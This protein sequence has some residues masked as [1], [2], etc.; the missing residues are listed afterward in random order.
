LDNIKYILDIEFELNFME[1][2][3][4]KYMGY[5]E[6]SLYVKG[7]RYPPVERKMLDYYTSKNMVSDEPFHPIHAAEIMRIYIYYHM[8]EISNYPELIL[9]NPLLDKEN[10]ENIEIIYYGLNRIRHIVDDYICK[11][12]PN[13]TAED[14]QHLIRFMDAI[15][16]KYDYVFNE[17]VDRALE[18]DIDTKE[19]ILIFKDPIIKIRYDEAMRIK[20][21]ER[22]VKK[23]MEEGKEDGYT[24]N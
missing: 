23:L 4:R 6:G 10:K 8:C 11:F 12:I 21:N 3:I 5:V 7:F 24:A 17:N 20:E 9:D 1:N 22:I 2:I 19:F 16:L 14:Y 13:I 15:I 18:I